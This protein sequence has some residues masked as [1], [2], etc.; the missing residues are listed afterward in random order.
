MNDEWKNLAVIP[1]V[2][3]KNSDNWG[4]DIKAFADIVEIKYYEL[5]DGNKVY[6]QEFN[7]PTFCAEQVFTQ[8][9]KLAKEAPQD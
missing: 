5:V 9:S 6:K 1:S 4:Y 2:D 3:L 8:A 7:V